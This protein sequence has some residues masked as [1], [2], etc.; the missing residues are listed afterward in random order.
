[1]SP[2]EINISIQKIESGKGRAKKIEMTQ[3]TKKVGD[4]SKRYMGLRQLVARK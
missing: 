3:N 2:Q 4:F 1:M